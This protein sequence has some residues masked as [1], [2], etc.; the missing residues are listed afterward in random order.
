MNTKLKFRIIHMLIFSISVGP[1]NV[2]T[3]LKVLEM[4]VK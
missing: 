1:G 4:E 2:Q 3:P